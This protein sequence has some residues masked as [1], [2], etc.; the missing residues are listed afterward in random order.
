MRELIIFLTVFF[1]IFVQ[2]VTGFGLALV[3]M[4]IL[5]ALLGVRVATPLV[6]LI[7]IS[8]ETYLLFRYRG[9]IE[10]KTVWPLILAGMVG[11]PF[12]VLA[13][14][15]LDEKIVL[16]LMGILIIAYSLYALFNF[17]LPSLSGNIWSTIFGFSSGV[18]GGAYNITGP[19]IIIY[20]NCRRWQPKEFK[21]NLQGFFL[22]GSI[23]AVI[24]HAL[25]HNFTKEVLNLFLIA[26]PAVALGLITGVS[27]D[28]YINPVIFR[29]IVLIG[30][31]I[32]G[33]SLIIR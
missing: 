15:I 14:K 9:S 10:I 7:A 18:L 1:A 6:V 13:I 20:G 33:F 19:L 5:A 24:S 4:P 32:S 22:L 8:A 17:K 12:G 30:L 27:L 11:I 3:S 29:K 28:K 25:V 21:G 16:T 31:V 26:I 2:S 23:V